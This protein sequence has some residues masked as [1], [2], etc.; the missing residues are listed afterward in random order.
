MAGEYLPTE[1][2]EVCCGFGGTYSLK[3][4]EISS[5]LMERKLDALEASGADRLVTDC[6]GCVLQLRGG[7]QKRGGGLPVEHLSEFLARSLKPTS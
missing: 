4:P 3:F 1:G 6:P 2:E 7:E 5:A